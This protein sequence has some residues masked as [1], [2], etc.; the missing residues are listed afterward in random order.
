MTNALCSCDKVA[1]SGMR[2]L[3][4]GLQCVEEGVTFLG[5]KP[6]DK[7]GCD[8]CLNHC[9]NLRSVGMLNRNFRIN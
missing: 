9:T 6:I 3:V 7:Y 5:I 4:T 1:V 8:T 2:A